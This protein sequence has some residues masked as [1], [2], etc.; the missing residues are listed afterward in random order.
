MP[1]GN[2]IVKRRHTMYRRKLLKRT[3]AAGSGVPYVARPCFRLG[4]SA[5]TIITIAIAVIGIL[6]CHAETRAQNGS[7]FYAAKCPAVA[8]KTWGVLD[9]DGANRPTERYLSSL[10]SGEAQVGSIGSPP[11]VI[12]AETIGFTIRGH[13]GK[14]GGRGEN[15]IA[16][17]D[18]KTGNV[19]RKA[20]A[21]G[22]DAL[23]QRQW[24]VADLKGRTVRIEVVDG[25]SQSGYAWLGVGRID[26][27][28]DMTIDFRQGIPD[29][30]KTAT[31]L[32]DEDARKRILLGDGPV[33]FQ[34]YED[35]YTWIPQNG[36]A[37]IPIGT[38][39]KRLFLLGCTVPANEVLE[40]YGYID[41][42][43]TDN[44]R[45]TY[46][47]VYGFTLE[48]AYKTA[49]R[50]DA[51]HVLPVGDATQHV[52]VIRPAEKV[53][54]KIELRRVAGHLP[55][56]RVSAITCEVDAAIP[57]DEPGNTAGDA[58]EVL[59]P[60][61]AAPDDLAWIAG[62]TLSAAGPAW[63]QLADKIREARG[64]R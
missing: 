5:P 55:R 30:W 26:A 18:N 54:Q 64:A 57:N 1:T 35:A 7:R 40:T 6:C 3:V 27:G 9:R 49:R 51:L 34:L 53:I 22:S 62:H 12:S 58:L 48:G 20:P 61:A 63:E 11:F 52:L 32:P 19:L 25:N 60:V 46:P 56:P 15:F 39:A 28:A 29:D 4:T 21:P 33:P 16:L 24:D 50:Y 2:P 17:L 10:E 31:R 59:E 23:I 14:D 38:Q 13:D 43:Y 47:L 8:G 45:E 41:V 36:A 37:Q 44:S 42:V